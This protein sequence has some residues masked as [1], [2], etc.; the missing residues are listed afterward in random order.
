MEDTQL[1]LKNVSFSYHSRSGEVRALD[2][3]SFHVSAVLPM[4]F[5]L[6]FWPA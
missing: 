2:S 5:T 6:R 3:V 4:S 1:S